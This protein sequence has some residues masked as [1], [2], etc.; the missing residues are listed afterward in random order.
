[1][2]KD[3]NLEE[4]DYITAE[5]GK[6]F[7]ARSP[8]SKVKVLGFL[9]TIF[10]KDSNLWSSIKTIAGESDVSPVYTRNVLDELVEKETIERAYVGKKQYFRMLKE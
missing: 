3:I 8:T 2:E 5:S 1:M 10:E 9:T 4:G 6:D 7:P